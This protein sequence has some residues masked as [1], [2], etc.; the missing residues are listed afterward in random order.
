MEIPMKNKLK[1]FYFIILAISLTACSAAE[2]ADPI[3]TDPDYT[4]QQIKFFS[5]N[6]N[7]YKTSDILSVEI[8]NMSENQ[9]I[10]PNNYNIRIFEKTNKGWT[11]LAEKPTIRLPEGDSMLNPQNENS[12]LQIINVFPDLPDLHQTYNLRIYVFGQ[13]SEKNK[14]IEVAAYTDVILKP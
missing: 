6:N 14:K 10:F 8:W 12:S 3:I 1:V 5:L 9:I 11:E 13:M 7:T 4:N 2:S